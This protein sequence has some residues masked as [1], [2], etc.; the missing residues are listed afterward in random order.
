MTRPYVLLSAAISVDGF[1][2]DATDERLLLSNA[3]DFDRV[4]QVRAESDAIMI[5]AGTIRADNPRLLVNSP[6]RRAAREAQGLPTFPLKVTITNTGDL[7]SEAKFWHHGGEKIV[8]CPASVTDKVKHTLGDLATVAAAGDST[9]DLGVLL[10]DLGS[11]GVR[12]LMVEGGSSVHTQFLTAGLADEIHLAVAPFFV[13]D[14]RA[15]RLVGDGDFVNNASRRMAVAE[16][17]MIGDVVLIRYLPK[18]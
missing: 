12:Q 15:P 14:S 5:G 8:Y 13:G 10:D 7:D 3:E 1:L 4:D 11:R 2:D 16:S 9:V 18:A 17:R 6:E